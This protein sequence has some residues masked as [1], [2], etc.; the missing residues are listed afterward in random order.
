MGQRNKYWQ[1]TKTEECK[2]AWLCVYLPE[3]LMMIVTL[4][5][6]GP[7]EELISEVRISKLGMPKG[8]GPVGIASAL[9]TRVFSENIRFYLPN[10]SHLLIHWFFYFL[11]HLVTV[12]LCG[13]HCV[14]SCSHR[15]N[16]VT[17]ALSCSGSGKRPCK[18]DALVSM[19]MAYLQK[20]NGSFIC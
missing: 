18:A 2:W 6:K 20:S 12:H 19:I 11:I 15:W 8:L 17:W 3:H 5:S 7:W 1:G 9:A 16:R 13:R 4:C 14:I 10:K